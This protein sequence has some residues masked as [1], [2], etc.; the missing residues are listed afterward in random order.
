MSELL[1]G[2]K[3]L[4]TVVLHY[5]IIRKLQLSIESNV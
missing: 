5:E 1:P 4:P 3:D 2:D